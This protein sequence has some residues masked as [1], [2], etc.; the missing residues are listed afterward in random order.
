MPGSSVVTWK[1]V[2]WLNHT[3]SPV[4]GCRAMAG[5][6]ARVLRR[7]LSP[8]SATMPF[9]RQCSSTTDL[10]EV[11]KTVCQSRP[12]PSPKLRTYIQPFRSK[13][14]LTAGEMRRRTLRQSAMGVSPPAS[15]GVSQKKKMSSGQLCWYEFSL[16]T[17]MLWADG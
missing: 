10:S 3:S 1:K 2:A 14:S 7:F 4:R 16:C 12:K 5:R 9:A 17:K 6:T 13:R 11:W 8:H 15:E